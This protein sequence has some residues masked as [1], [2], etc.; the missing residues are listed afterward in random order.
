[1][2]GA[3][4]VYLY[5]SKGKI[6]L[7]LILSLTYFILGMAVCIYSFKEGN[8]VDGYIFTILPLIFGGS[9][10]L[11]IKMLVDLKPYL[12]LTKDMFIIKHP[13]KRA[14]FI[15][16]QDIKRYQIYK[17]QFTSS[18]EIY[19]A[20]KEEYKAF[21]KRLFAGKLLAKRLQVDEIPHI[22]KVNF[23]LSLSLTKRKDRTKL[24]KELDRRAFG[25]VTDERMFEIAEHRQLFGVT[26]SDTVPS[27]MLSYQVE[28][29]AMK[30]EQPSQI[31]RKYFLKIIA[32]SLVIMIVI[33]FLLYQIIGK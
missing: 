9:T 18:I 26:A 10:L 19:L 7:A 33:F 16:W 14:I 2:L 5:V 17:H 20:E 29:E 13:L 12:T 4:E 1:M 15:Q 6:F 30:V 11:A 24:L 3:Q 31:K 23:L 22:I 28:K 32:V 8:T 27:K 25:S 21:R